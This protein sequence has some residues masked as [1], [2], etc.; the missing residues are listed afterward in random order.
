[1]NKLILYIQYTNPANYPPLL[2]SSQI[3]ANDGWK[4]VFLGTKSQGDCQFK[5]DSGLNVRVHLLWFQRPGFFQKIHYILYCLWGLAYALVFR[6]RWVYASE[7]LAS[8]MAC[9]LSVIGYKVIYHEHDSP[10]STEIEHGSVLRLLQCRK[11]AALK[12]VC[13][14]LP[15]QERS[16]VFQKSTGCPNVV[17]VWN[18]PSLSEVRSARSLR[19]STPLR[20]LY[21]GSIVPARLP[22]AVIDAL[23]DSCF[24]IKLRIVG[25]ETV[26]YQ[27]HVTALLAR[28]SKLGISNRI[29]F[30]KAVATRSELMELCAECDIGLAFMP[31]QSTSINMRCMTGASNKPFDYLACGLGVLVSDLPDWNELYVKPGYG[32]AC[33]PED[34]VSIRKALMWFWDHPREMAAMGEKGRHKILSDWNYEKQFERVSKLMN[35]ER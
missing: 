4:V 22:L 2:H 26:G 32:L 18:C 5:L 14:I 11:Q 21:H 8:P 3:L 16:H 31:M 7:L 34:S 1:M 19:R 29:E 6:P 9:F 10:D 17:T 28:A 33:N 13:C 27:G 12:S 30:R 20:V 24:D 25:Y 15:N 23:A 35:M